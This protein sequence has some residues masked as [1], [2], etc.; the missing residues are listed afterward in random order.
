MMSRVIEWVHDAETPRVKVTMAYNVEPGS[1]EGKLVVKKPGVAR[2]EL[3]GKKYIFRVV[4]EPAL[5]FIPAGK[6]SEEE[7]LSTWGILEPVPP[8]SEAKS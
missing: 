3:V 5:E 7:T 4:E 6:E 2:L 1:A 8:S